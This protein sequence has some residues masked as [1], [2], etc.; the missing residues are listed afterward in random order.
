MNMREHWLEQRRKG[1]GGS[2]AAAALGQSPHMTA[3]ELYYDKI[4]ERVPRDID[5]DGIERTDFGRALE[6]VVASQYASRYGVRLRRR[7]TIIRHAKHPHM[8]A[9]VDRTIDG[10]KAGLE[11]KTVDPFA[12]RHS[13]L[14]GEPGGDE[15]PPH[16]LLQCVHY[17][18]C[19]D[20]PVWYLAALVGGHR[21]V[22]YVIDRDR[23]LEQMVI[24]G[25]CRFW[26]HVETREPPE[27]DYQH[28]HAIDLLKRLYTGTDGGTIDLDENVWYWHRVRIEADERVKS[29]QAVSDGARAHILH[30]MGEAAI[31]RLPNGGAYKRKTV[32]RPAYQ[33]EDCDYTTLTYSKP[34]ADANRRDDE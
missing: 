32:H 6:G 9:N 33:V 15:V 17:M 19:L 27:L 21:M 23:E 8:I 25:E 34:K 22:R 14:W 7:N 16:Y 29:Y 1:V 11:I 31:G 5:A 24:D 18:A 12:F 4:G 20:Y 28:P 30:V 13:G 2:D 10:M 3:L 26:T